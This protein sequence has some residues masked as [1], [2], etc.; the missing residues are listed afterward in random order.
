MRATELLH[1]LLATVSFAQDMSRDNKHVEN[2]IFA[3]VGAELPHSEV[4][5]PDYYH[6]PAE[7]LLTSVLKAREDSEKRNSLET[8]REFPPPPTISTNSIETSSAEHE[9]I[10][11]AHRIDHSGE[12]FIRYPMKLWLH[13]GMEEVII[14]DFWRFS[15]LKGL[16][17]SCAILFVLGAFYEALKGLRLNLADVKKWKRKDS[18]KLPTV[19]TVTDGRALRDDFKDL[20]SSVPLVTNPFRI[21]D[22]Q[23]EKDAAKTPGCFSLV[24]IVQALV[25]MV[26][27]ALAFA[28][29]LVVMTYNVWLILAIVLGAGIGHWM[30]PSKPSVV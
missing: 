17:I 13:G 18:F 25:Y 7:L 30:F 24:R 14:F 19:V 29:M 15:D 11:K 3:I 6:N 26:Q 22:N 9:S 27:M 16:F 5:V 2:G 1:F 23:E 8:S 10:V 28:L 12:N 20:T 21:V 4:P